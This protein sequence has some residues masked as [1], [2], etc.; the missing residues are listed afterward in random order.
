MGLES[1]EWGWSPWNGVGL[2]PFHMENTRECK[3]LG[4]PMPTPG[5][6]SAPHFRGKCVEDF[7]DSLDQHADSA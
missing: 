7:L 5:T 1:M 2:H 3:D 6:P 4:V